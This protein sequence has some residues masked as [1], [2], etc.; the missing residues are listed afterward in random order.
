MYFRSLSTRRVLALP[1]ILL[2][3]LV[4][5]APVT[6]VQAKALPRGSRQILTKNVQLK[7]KRTPV[8]GKEVHVTGKTTKAHI[9]HG[10]SRPAHSFAFVNIQEFSI[11]SANSQPHNITLGSDGAFWFTEANANQ[12]G[13]ITTAGAITEYTVATTGANPSGITTGPDGNIWFTEQSGNNIG[14]FNMTTLAITEYPIP[15]PSAIVYNITTGPD[16]ALWFPESGA[17]KIGRIT[18]SGTITEYKIPTAGSNAAFIATGPDGNLW[19]S[20]STA[21]KIGQITTGASPTITEFMIPTSGSEPEGIVS[22]PGGA[23]W[24]C[25]FSANK[26]GRITTSGLFS[27]FGVPTV[28]SEPF[29]IASAGDGTLA[30]TEFGANQIGRIDPTGFVTESVIPTQSS[31]PF[32]ITNGGPGIAW[33]IEFNTNKIAKLTLPALAPTQPDLGISMTHSGSSFSVG[34]N[35]SYSVAITNA[36]TAASVTPPSL[37]SVTITVPTGLSNITASGTGWFVTAASSSSPT[38]IS[39][40][41][42]GSYPITAGQS[43]PVI[44]MQGTLTK[45]AASSSVLTTTTVGVPGDGNPFNNLATDTVTVTGSTP[46]SPTPTPTLTPTPSP[47]L[48]LTPTPSSTPTP[49]ST[50]GGT[51]VQINAGGGA[52]APFVADTDFS[53][54]IVA[55]SG[56]TID[57]SGVINPAPQAVYQSNRYGNFSYIIA[58][59][60]PDKVY[61]VRLHFAETYWTQAGSRIFDVSANSQSILSNF[62]IVATAGSADKAVVAEADVIADGTGTITLQFSTV[63]DNA[64]VNGIEIL[65]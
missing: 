59:L 22:G 48:T 17:D 46:L 21:S 25:E 30:F 24:F 43:L 34:Q 10:G 32:G 7:S 9:T 60:T 36:S 31:G 37:V 8:V 62:D 20:E 47:T 63:K 40:F 39:A 2:L 16:G 4:A 13:R 18:T 49:T 5:L 11:T 61:T 29:A 41:Y 64:Q 26:I 56:N 52:A 51:G 65:P 55:T 23:L 3:L 35:V 53:G 54:G 12:L 50:P 42:L 27:E 45:E 1:L 19:F 28:S 15:T 58:N 57:T 33:F 14:V 38:L 44:S 6:L